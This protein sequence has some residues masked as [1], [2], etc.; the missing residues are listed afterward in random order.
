MLALFT[1]VVIYSLIRFG[2]QP[3]CGCF[4]ELLPFSNVASLAKNL[5]LIA[6]TFYLY[7]KSSHK[8]FHFWWIPLIV[9]A[10][11]ILTV[12]LMHKIPVYGKEF[13]FKQE[14]KAAY[15]HRTFPDNSESLNKK[16]LMIFLSPNC[17]GCQK[18]A[19]KLQT[20]HHIYKLRDAYIFIRDEEKKDIEH[21]FK[22]GIPPLPSQP[23]EPDT[24]D[25]YMI[26]PF[27]PLVALVDEHGIYKNLWTSYNFNLNEVIPLL[28]QEGI[29]EK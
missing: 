20:I 26:A 23:L 2:N 21:L 15:L 16:H 18:M 4:G 1:L 29:L 10:I 28:Q 25:T 14:V 8:S 7:K 6:L 27:L 17:S 24:F 3:N 11:S 9:L 13:K 5:A 22:N 19:Q 12:F